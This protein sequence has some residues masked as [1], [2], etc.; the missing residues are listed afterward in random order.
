[1]YV[2]VARTSGDWWVKNCPNFVQ[3]GGV[4]KFGK[5]FVGLGGETEIDEENHTTNDLIP[6]ELWSP[7][8][9]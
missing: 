8:A 3:I 1:M 6:A 5:S 7:F 4:C 2:C 9:N